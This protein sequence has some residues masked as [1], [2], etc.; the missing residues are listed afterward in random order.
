MGRERLKRERGKIAKLWDERPGVIYRWLQADTPAWGSA[1]ILLADGQQCLTVDA[2][3]AAVQAFWVARV[4]RKNVETDE[5][6]AWARF[7]ESAFFKHIPRGQFPCEPWTLARVQAV[8]KKLREGSAPGIPIA[9]WKCLPDEFLKG[10]AELLTLIEANGEWPDELLQAYVAMI[11]KAS[12]GSRPQDQRPI[13]VLDVAYRIWAKGS[14]LSWSPTLQTD[15]LGPSVT[16]FRA[17]SGT[18][19]LAQLLSDLIALQARRKAPLWLIS[20][21]IEKCFPSLPWWGLFGVLRSIGVDERIVH[22]LHNF[23]TKL[24]HRFRYGQ[25]DGSEWSMTN[26]LAQGC[27]A[28]PDLMNILFEPFHRWAAAQQ[29][30]VFVADTYV[31]SASFADDVTLIATSWADAVFLIQGYYLWCVLLDIKLHADKTQVWTNVG[32]PTQEVTLQFG[33]N[34]VKLKCRETFRVVGIELGAKERLASHHHYEPRLKKAL[35]TGRRLAALNVPAAVAAEMY[36]ATVLAQGL[37]GC[38][39]RHVAPALT[40]PLVQQAKSMIRHK[41]PLKLSHYA[42]SEVTSGLPLGACAFRDPRLEMLTRRVRWLR[43]LSN[44]QGL[45]GTVHRT[46]ATLDSPSWKEPSAALVAGLHA[47]N[48]TIHRNT[49]CARASRWPHLDSERAYSGDVILA[50]KPDDPPVDAVWT[51]GSLRGSGGAAV[52]QMSTKV[53][54]LC[55]V[56]DPRSSTQCELVALAMVSLFQPTPSLVLT[57]SLC[58]LQQISAWSHKSSAAVLS[59]AD[60]VEV[61]RFLSLWTDHPNPPALEKVKAHD[62][63]GIRDG[64]PKTLGNEK[65]DML[66]KQAT[67]VDNPIY[68][69]DDRFADAVQLRDDQGRWLRDLPDLD[70]CWWTIQL[71]AAA[72]RRSWFSIVYPADVDIDWEASCYLFRPPKVKDGNF[73]F[74]AAPFVLKWTARARTGGLASRSRLLKNTLVDSAQCPCCPHPDEDDEHMVAGCEGTGSSDCALFAVEMWQKVGRARNARLPPLPADWVAGHLYMIAVGLIPRSLTTFV[75]ASFD[76][77][78]KRL[79]R[80]FHLGMTTRLAEVLRRRQQLISAASPP[81]SHPSDLPSGSSAPLSILADSARHLTVADLRHAER[82]PAPPP[83][84][85]ARRPGNAAAAAGLE[86]GRVLHT[87]VKHHRHLRAVPIADGEPTVALMLLWEADHGKTFPCRAVD[88]VRRLGIFAKKFSEAVA[89]DA[90]L[91]EWLSSKKLF[92]QLSPGISASKYVKW[93]VKIDSTVGEP[94]LGA[95]KAYLLTLVIPAAPPTVVPG[96]T[97]AVPVPAAPRPIRPRAQLGTK[98]KPDGDAKRPPDNSKR[99]RIE[100]L[101]AAKA[102]MAA[103]ASSSSSV[104]PSSSSPS[105]ALPSSGD[106]GL[107][108]GVP[109]RAGLATPGAIT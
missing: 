72:E 42:A 20:F 84:P 6:A 86:A 17:Q 88:F 104:V 60:R 51:D 89:A 90:E 29:K 36:R 66:A 102:A 75:P 5:A 62:D 49:L 22:C 18:L 46:L 54:H 85:P 109:S 2:V 70:H 87:W 24:R 100:R 63:E 52:V 37:Y 78:T 98:R 9:V 8:V 38:E 101:Q 1:P 94:F 55:Q 19:H 53:R 13:T 83:K 26:G 33:A 91:S 77:L 59:C 71:A 39:I 67:E 79:L 25:V 40:Q 105:S 4:W 73:V 106:G 34:S 96:A 11:P 35:M 65:A 108:P 107:P 23:Y 95:W 14:V 21:D 69:P 10:L 47:L 57:D 16:G 28:S 3:D 68:E 64:N 56:P 31:A 32:S 44:A 58:S 82:H 99:T 41:H 30:G 43:V 61:R 15:C 74:M 92:A 81:P 103:E 45:V 48:W 93:S 7:Q 12:G 97:A 27:P 76:M 50:P 80:D